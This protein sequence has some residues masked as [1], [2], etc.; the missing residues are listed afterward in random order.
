[1]TPAEKIRHPQGELTPR[2]VIVGGDSPVAKALGKAGIGATI[3]DRHNP[4]LFQP[5]LYQVAT[6]ALSAPD[7]AE[8]IR[9][10]L[11]R[12]RSVQVLFGEVAEIELGAKLLRLD[13]GTREAR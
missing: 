8:P 12:Y 3:I 11:G 2:I 10:I 13:D 1:M 4:H 7:I 9:E 6:A 5:L